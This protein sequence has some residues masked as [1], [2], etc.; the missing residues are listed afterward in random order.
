VR[1][2]LLI[3]ALLVALP[4]HAAVS[5]STVWE[6]RAT[7]TSGNVNG[8]GFVT[9]GG[10]TDFT[11]QD[12]SQD[13]GTDLDT[14]DND[15]VG[16]ASHNFV[17][18]DVG[19][20]IHITAGSGF[21]VGWYE[22]TAVGSNNADLDRA[23]GTHPITGATWAYGG[24]CSLNSTLDDD[25]FEASEAGNIFWMEDGNYTLGESLNIG[26]DGNTTNAIRL[27]GYSSTRGDDPVGDTRPNIAAGALTML[28]DDYWHIRN[29]IVTGTSSDVLRCDIA[30]VARHVSSSNTSGTSNRASFRFGSAS[31][32][33]KYSDVSSTNGDAIFIQGVNAT[34]G[35]GVY[36]HDSTTCIDISSGID[37]SIIHFNIIETC[38]V[39]INAAGTTTD[40]VII[41]NTIWASTTSGTT[42]ILSAGASAA[43]WHIYNNIISGWGTGAN[44]NTLLDSNSSDFNNYFGN[45]T[46][47]TNLNVGNNDFDTD[48]SFTDAAGGD[49]SVG[50]AMDDSGFPG[51]IQGSSSTGHLVV[52]AV[53]R[54]TSG[55]GGGAAS[56]TFVQ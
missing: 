41:N 53:M 46:D 52:G 19:N 28:F 2:L 18:A 29:I 16:S 12:A 31:G 11:L 32:G 39:G 6:L 3:I 26:Q 54:S 34:V 47:R 43:E 35:P 14:V 40:V 51:A 24:A 10:G 56:F 33:L 38:T 4:A 55:G 42:G 27:E 22:I 30:C 21:T 7:A 9:G 8:C 36:I 23:V 49:F 20:F 5:A 1:K 13:S 44:F 50:S 48:P 15:T 45:T 17:A 37:A 25:M